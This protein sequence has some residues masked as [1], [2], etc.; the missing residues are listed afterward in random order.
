MIGNGHKK[1]LFWEIGVPAPIR[2]Y[3][4]YRNSLDLMKIDYLS[5]NW[6]IKRIFINFIL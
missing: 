4:Q 3:Y 5:L 2:H 6:K 1:I